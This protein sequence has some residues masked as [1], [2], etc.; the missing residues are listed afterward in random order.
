MFNTCNDPT[1]CS[2]SEDGTMI[3]VKNVSKFEND[4][5]PQFFKHN[6]FT[7]FVRQLNFYGFRKI[8]NINNSI[9]IDAPTEKNWRFYHPKFQHNRTYLLKQMKRSPIKKK[10]KKTEQLTT[11]TTQS[12]GISNN[13]VAKGTTIDDD[14]IK[15]NGDHQLHNTITTT[16]ATTTV[17]P[18]D[19]PPPPPPPPP[20]HLLQSNMDDYSGDNNNEGD[21]LFGEYYDS[22][23]NSTGSDL[24]F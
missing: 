1:V 21:L 2:W 17:T 5:I 23:C 16:T 24:V 15:C 7:S 22:D 4:I 13:N 14:E 19:I 10:E 18:I 6:K 8:N 9:R 12:V 3:V 11:T 20:S